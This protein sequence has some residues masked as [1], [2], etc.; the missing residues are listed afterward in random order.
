V[1]PQKSAII[2]D[3]W[4]ARVAKLNEARAMTYELRVC[5][6]LERRLSSGLE[7]VQVAKERIRTRSVNSASIDTYTSVHDALVR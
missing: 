5:E 3:P 6:H 7:Y 4:D 2:A 1:T